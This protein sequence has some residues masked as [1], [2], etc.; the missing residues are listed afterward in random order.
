MGQYI[1]NNIVIILKFLT[2]FSKE[3]FNIGETRKTDFATTHC[4][5]GLGKSSVTNESGENQYSKTTD[6]KVLGLN[7]K[8]A[9][10][11]SSYKYL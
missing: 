10:K 2:L 9:T 8:A 11:K 7:P 3:R 4:C 1:M 6:L 5:R